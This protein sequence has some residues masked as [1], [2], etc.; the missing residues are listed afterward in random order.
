[1][2]APVR[3][4]SFDSALRARE[5]GLTPPLH[6]STIRSFHA[7]GDYRS[8]LRD[9]VSNAMRTYS[10]TLP[11]EAHKLN[12]IH[13]STH[14]FLSSAAN[15]AGGARLLLP[16]RANSDIVIGVYDNDPA[17]VVSYALSSKEYEDWVTDRSYENGGIW[18]TIKRSKEDSAASSS[19]AWQSLGSMD[20]DPSSSLGTLFMDSKKSPHLTISYEDASS[21]AG[22]KNWS[23]QGGKSNVYFA[24]SLDERF[25]IKQVKKTELESFEVFAPEYFKYLTDSLNTGSP[26]CLAKILGIYQVTVKHLKG[27]KETKMDLMV[28]ENLFFNRNIGRVYDLKGSSRSRYNPDTS[29][30]NKVLLDTNLVERLRTEPIFLGSKAKRSLERAIWNDTSFLASVD[31]MDYSLLV[32]VD[33]ERKELVLGIIDFMRQYT[34]DKHLETWV[35]ASGILGGPKNASP[36]IVSPKQY[37]KRFRKAMTSYFLTVPDQWSS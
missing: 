24:K 30:S 25:I 4:H 8:M 12:L 32:G 35:K 31:V 5:K 20:L 36:T 15:M 10:Q 14:S 23:A 19:T 22:G 21:I 16:V 34:W 33:D 28:M 7:S 37:K 9:P 11:L 18:S 2:V 17:S 13:G 1:M 3:V 6:F 26:T 29:G 27:V